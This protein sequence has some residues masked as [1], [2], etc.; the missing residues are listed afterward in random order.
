MTNETAKDLA[1][2]ALKIAGAIF[3][4]LGAFLSG[5]VEM[6]PDH[7]LADDVRRALPAVGASERA[8]RELDD[9]S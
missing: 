3:P 2:G 9:G 8:L 1:L 5:L 4:P 7:P 6:T